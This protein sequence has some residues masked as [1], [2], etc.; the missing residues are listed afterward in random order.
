MS[1]A[2]KYILTER[3][4]QGGMAEIHLGKSVGLD[5]FARVCAFKRI[6]P[7][8][9]QDQEFIQ[10]FRNEAMV[11][12]Q[13]QNKNIVQVFDFVSDGTSFMLVME[14]VDGQDLRSVLAQAEQQRKRIPTE[15]AC[16]LAIE[17]LSGLAYAHAAVDISG[18]SMG[19]IHRDVSPQNVLVSYEGDVKITDFGIAKAQNQT[20][21]TRA[22]VLK[23]KFRY[24]SPEQ[25]MGQSVDGRSDVFAIGVILW[26]MLT[27]Q[28]LFKGEDMAVLEAVRQCRIKPP[29]QI[30]GTKVP[31]ELDAIVLRLLSKDLT[32]RH[33]S[34]KE[35]IRD[36]NKFLYSVRSDFFAG[37]VAEFMHQLFRERIASARERLRSTLALPVGQLGVGGGFEMFGSSDPASSHSSV[38]DMSKSAAKAAA[39]GAGAAVPM[40]GSGGGV[41]GGPFGGLPGGPSGGPLGR[42]PSGGRGGGPPLDEVLTNRPPARVPPVEGKANARLQVVGGRSDPGTAVKNAQ[43]QKPG[44]PARPRLKAADRVRAQN[45]SALKGGEGLGAEGILVMAV[46]FVVGLFLGYITLMKLGVVAKASEMTVEVTPA[47]GKFQVEI[48]GKP[49]YKNQF[50]GSP[51]RLNLQGN[52]EYAL[53]IKRPGFRQRAYKLRTPLFGGLTRETIILEKSGSPMASLR[54]VTTPPGA[55]V[56]LDEGQGEGTS[57]QTFPFLPVG[58]T[59]DLVV[60]HSKCSGAF[61]DKVTLK[62]GDERRE[63]IVKTYRF[64]GCKN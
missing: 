4:A 38:V 62:P 1:G 25:A 16:Y 34:A 39:P 17:V 57:P 50:V 32:K 52:K 31:P 49:L 2:P 48:D 30:A 55:L 5:G 24:M 54:V 44:Q 28:R 33:Q 23:G 42:P 51:L 12:K 37:E 36:L 43:G 13:L 22:G 64:K 11:A 14:F 53:V 45:S 61:R 7:H 6:L 15:I 3:I 8:Y 20:S 47:G 63:L 35:A 18:K 10:M 21:T 58:K 29:S 27:M 40:V 56:V 26:E 60:T 41:S 46:V 59:Y 9:A 19:I